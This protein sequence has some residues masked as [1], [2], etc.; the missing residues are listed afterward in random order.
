MRTDSYR[1]ARRTAV[2][3]QKLVRVDRDQHK[4]GIWNATDFNKILTGLK[5]EYLP[6]NSPGA[7]TRLCWVDVCT[8]FGFTCPEL[9]PS[10]P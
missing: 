4:A 5:S 3:K 7:A 8:S 9:R 2:I 10:P 6:S 1:R